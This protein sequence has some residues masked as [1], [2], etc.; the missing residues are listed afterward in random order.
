[1]TEGDNIHAWTGQRF[2][3]CALLAFTTVLVLVLICSGGLVT[4]HG[5]GMTVPDWPTSYGYNMFLFPVS[6]WVGGIFYEHT[7]RLL[8]SIVGF[9]TMV[10][11]IWLVI[12][13]PRR[14]VKILAV[15]A[16]VAVVIQGLLGGFRVTL[17]MDEIG[18]FHAMLAQTFLSTMVILTVVTS[19]SFVEGRFVSGIKQSPLRWFA[20]VLVALIFFQLGLAATMRHEHTDLSI[21]DFPLAYGKIWP[22]TSAVAVEKINVERAEEGLP[23]TSGVQILLQMFHRIVAVFILAGVAAFAWL[24]ASRL[25]PLSRKL[26]FAWVL[27]VFLQFGFGAWT[28]WSGKAA[29]VTTVHVFLGATCL[30]LGVL[31]T[32]RLFCGRLC[33]VQSLNPHS[34]PEMELA[35]KLSA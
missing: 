9:L 22:D 35:A 20:A 21:R 8:A 12:I 25:D 29:D 13:E 24:A 18:I 27:I 34:T 6:R 10:S 1:M 23:A 4:S 30:F 15:T 3:V 11:A 7:H 14:W 32:F 17:Y 5:A 28:V 16:F 33:T 2:G 26:A 31:L 19:R